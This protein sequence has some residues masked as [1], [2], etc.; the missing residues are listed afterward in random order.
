MEFL[1]PLALFGLVGAAAPALLH[2]LQRR[3]PPT[4][5]FP[6]VRY[7]VEAERRDSR[8]L[9]LRNLLLLVLRT[10]LIAALAL[11]AARPVVP[12]SWGSVH[13]PSAVAVVLDNSASSGVIVEGQARFET[14][15]EV[16]RAIGARATAADRLWRITADGVPERLSAAEWESTIDALT[17]VPRRLDLGMAVRAAGA[18][19]RAQELPATVVV[20]SDL[21]E[22]ALTPASVGVPVVALTAAPFGSVPNRGV[23][24]V[25]VSSEI[26]SPGG[27]VVVEVGG[28]GAAAG[29][30]DLALGGAIVAR[31]LA[32]PGGSV[33]LAVDRIGPGWH[34]ATIALAPDEM[35]ADNLFHTAL[36]GAVPAAVS[37]LGAGEFVDAGLATLVAAGR[38]RAGRGVV[39]GDRP[40]RGATIVLPPADPARVPAANQ[41]LAARGIGIRFGPL[42]DGEWAAA[43]DLV[44]LEG[45]TV[46]RRHR[47]DGAGVT[48]ATAG[49]EPWLVRV[50]DVVVAASRLE[51]AWTDLPLRPAFIP[52]L[53]ALVTRVGTGGSWRVHAAPGEAVRLPGSGGRVLLPAGAVPANADGRLDAPRE[54]GTYFVANAAGDTVGALLVNVDPRESDLAV[55][56][57]ALIRDR[58]SGASVID[59]PDALVRAAFAERRAEI[60]TVLLVLA[61]VLAVAELLLATLGGHAPRR[62]G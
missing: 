12:A 53:D 17:P 31:G 7:L 40:D 34:A 54:P 4:L 59:D 9:R 61:L 30:V 23:A 13:A 28:R 48:L 8:R 49:G 27:S 50:G 52:F 14:L 2:L 45:A 51:D 19:L 3:Q 38:V 46:W 33:V 18:L 16:A 60:T 26:W 1:Q 55:A 5:P 39:V 43:S 35:R 47:L 20:M 62:E 24:S 11:A 41:A 10:A 25:R 56:S 42:R 21:Q 44:P 57:P 22:S 32:G 15:R 36:R 58:L 6:P 37:A 29:E